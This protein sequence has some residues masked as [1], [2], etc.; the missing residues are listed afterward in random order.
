MEPWQALILGIVEG[1]TEYLPV[2]STGHLLV[3]QRL[4]GIPQTAAS[5][6]YAIAIQAGAILAVV[7]LYR[8]RIVQMLLGVVGR[9]PVGARLALALVVGFLPAGVIGLLLDDTIARYLFGLWPVVAAWATLGLVVIAI[10]PGLRRRLGGL[11]IE[12]VGPRLA[13]LVG[14]AQCAAMW[15][16]VSRSLATILG[17]L[18][19][20][21][22]LTAAIELSFLLGLVT[23]GAATTY[24]AAQSGAVML[25]SYRPLAIGVGFLAAWVSAV[26]AVRW[27][28]AWLA[29]RG[30]GIFGWWRVLAAAAVATLVLTGHLV[31][32]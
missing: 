27:M 24:T 15:P 31:A 17:G 21:L 18:A 6:A 14:L 28:V 20:G 30:L 2:S 23:L 3:T 5:N 1:L 12:A 32:S 9:D 26:L 22:S 7:G 8:V 16:G 10:A 13:F 19:V 29:H 11:G 25:E 4:L